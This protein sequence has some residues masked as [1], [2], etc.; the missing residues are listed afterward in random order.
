[1]KSKPRHLAH[2]V[3][4]AAKR[5]EFMAS[6]FA[7]YCAAERVDE[8]QLVSLLNCSEQDYLRLS[9]CRTSRQPSADDLRQL[10]AFAGTDPHAL[11]RVVRRVE[12]VEAMKAGAKAVAQ[13]T[14]IA[15]RERE[16]QGPR[17]E[18]GQ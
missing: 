1:M 3:K 9:L 15:A 11:A 4:R 16:E 7:R 18:G 5:P 13:S 17:D 12:A 10:A 8:E 6:V 14:L 2:A